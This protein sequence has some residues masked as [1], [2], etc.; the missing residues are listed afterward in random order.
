MTSKKT[1]DFS[2]LKKANI[3]QKLWEILL[4]AGV[5]RTFGSGEAIYVQGQPNNGLF[6]LVRGKIKASIIFADGTEKLFNIIEAPALIG[7]SAAFDGGL[8]VCSA[9]AITKTEVACVNSDKARILLMEHPEVALLLIESIGKKLRCLALQA[10]DLS[11]YNISCRLAR[12]LLNFK[13]YGMFTYQ[14]DE[15]CLLITH[16]ELACFI[17]TTRPNVTTFLND[18]ARKGLIEL[19]RGRIIIREFEGLAIYAD[20]NTNSQKNVADCCK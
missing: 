10:E 2:K 16:E 15:N 11:A 14:D 1:Y 6:C 20:V 7:E 18:F 4:N 8:C 5:H 12:M 17:G 13:K 9:T 3:N 19:K